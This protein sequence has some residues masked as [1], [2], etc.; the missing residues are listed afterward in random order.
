[1]SEEHPHKKAFQATGLSGL[2]GAHFVCG[3]LARNGWIPTLTMGN[4]R[5]VDVIAVRLDP[6]KAVA[7]QVKTLKAQNRG[8]GW[9]IKKENITPAI[10]YLLVEMPEDGVPPKFLVLNASEME[11]YSDGH[12]KM[13]SVK[14]PKTEERRFLSRWDRLLTEESS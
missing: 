14:V 9:L 8:T 1:L 10:F 7:I 13:N 2:S 5:K 6:Q 11:N 4:M 3:E 12:P